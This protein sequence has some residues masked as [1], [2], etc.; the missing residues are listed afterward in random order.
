[1]M[2]GRISRLSLAASLLAL[3]TAGCGSTVTLQ[4]QGQ[5]GGVSSDGLSAPA[6]SSLHGSQGAVPGSTGVPSGR[7][8]NAGSVL[9]GGQPSGLTTSPAQQAG[10]SGVGQPAAGTGGGRTGVTGPGVTPTTIT[11]GLVY[12][13]N[14]EA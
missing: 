11:I 13:T 6:G 1:M 12:I 5:A 4:G 7:G 3:A 14:S 9:G 10:A 8:T 2:T